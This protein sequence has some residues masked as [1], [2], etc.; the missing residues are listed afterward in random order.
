MAWEFDSN[1]PIFIQVVERLQNDIVTGV[2]K[3]GDK[4]PSVREL[5]MAAGVNPNTMQRALQ[6]LEHTGL[7][8]TN[9]TSGKFVTDNVSDIQRANESAVDKTVKKF[10]E[11]MKALDVKGEEIL[12]LVKGAIK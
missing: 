10:I 1:K 6:E 3:P 5:A 4:I 11:D 7:I 8:Y 2:Y 9:R 12:E